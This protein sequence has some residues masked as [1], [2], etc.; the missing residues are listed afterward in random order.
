MC[1]VSTNLSARKAQNPH[2]R[3]LINKPASDGNIYIYFARFLTNGGSIIHFVPVR[4]ENYSGG[5]PTRN[6]RSRAAISARTFRA[7]SDARGLRKGPRFRTGCCERQ[8]P[9]PPPRGVQEIL[10][11]MQHT[12]VNSLFHASAFHSLDAKYDEYIT[13]FFVAEFSAILKAKRRGESPF[14]KL[15]RITSRRAT[16]ERSAWRSS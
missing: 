10:K 2:S 3:I 5:K 15:L 9:L 4:L 14:R 12:L 13:P 1:V 6:D 16:R 8:R 11:R 7:K